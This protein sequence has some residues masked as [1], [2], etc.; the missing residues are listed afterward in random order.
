MKQLTIFI[1]LAICFSAN[2]QNIC[3]DSSSH[4]QYKT[5][6]NDSLRVLKTIFTKDS[7]KISIGF[8]L[9]DASAFSNLFF[10][11]KTNKSGETVWFKKITSP[12]FSG[13]SELQS[14]GEAANGNIIIAGTN[15]V[16][17]TEPFFYIILSPQGQ[18]LYQ[19]NI[20]ITNAGLNLN[21]AYPIWVSNITQYGT[22]SLL[23][24]ITHPLYRA[25]EEPDAITL[26][27]TSNDG[28]PGSSWSFIRP[29]I[30]YYE[31]Y[32]DRCKIEGDYI[33]LYGSSNFINTC[34]I[35][36]IPQSAYTYL[37]INWKTKQVVDKKAYCSPPEG[38][39]QF[40]IPI[41]EGEGNDNTVVAILNND[42]ISIYRKIWGLDF[43]GGDTLTRIFKISEF[44]KDFNHI[45]SEYVC[46]RKRF[47]WWEEWNYHLYI[48]SLDNRYVSVYDFPNQQVYYAFGKD[49]LTIQKKIP[50]AATRIDRF[51]QKSNRVMGEPGYLTSYDIITGDNQHTYIDNFRILAKDTAALCFGSNIDL[52]LTKPAT[53][54]PINWQGNFT[55]QQAILALSPARFTIEDYN[56]QRTIVCNIVH[57]C[58][59]LKI[60]ALDTVCNIAQPVIVTV[61]KN[62]LC[63]GKINFTFDTAMVQTYQQ[64]NDTTLSLTFNKSYRGKIIARSASCDKLIDSVG[65]VVAAP[66]QQINLGNDTIYCPGKTYLFDAYNPGFK[67]YRWQ[68]GS[69]GTNYTATKDG[70][71]YVTAT[72]FCNRVYTDTIKLSKRNFKID[73]GKD[74]T[75]CLHE[76]MTLSVPAGYMNY[77]WQPQYNLTYLNQNSVTVIPEINTSYSVEAEV[78]QGCKLSDTIKIK[79]AACP[80]YIYFSNAFTPNNDGL[81]DLFK[82]FTGGAFEK[83][84]MQIYNR[85]G[86]LVFATKNRNE[87]WNGKYKSIAQDNGSFVW[88]CRYKFYGKPEQFIKGVLTLLK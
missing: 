26:L 16:T 87:G 57:R 80:E 74:S 51:S 86:Q 15:P 25:P 43:N 67:S 29:P 82:P 85:W 76:A 40:G 55:V 73:L 14:L 62:P 4:I 18:L 59:T 70:V 63:D 22:D 54:S 83:Y 47:R 9:K 61:Y 27:V 48:D 71:Y 1:S 53:V 37:K 7:S 56:L 81:N 72:D 64:I 5:L 8:F 49:L 58:D 46:T 2:A 38:F 36:F 24:C 60:H 44:D 23:F 65:L 34:M 79:V 41:T 50:H 88:Q 45:K 75:I 3:M 33:Y 32:F 28:V 39:T 11:S 84:E 30:T 12:N 42:R 66:F 21:N 77:S 17:A 19:N 35:S 6:P 78:F 52:L 31:P 10:A 69:N 13:K 68:D 20:D